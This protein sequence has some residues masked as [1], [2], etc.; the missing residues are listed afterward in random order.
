MKEEPTRLLDLVK[1]SSDRARAVLLFT[2]VACI[3]IFMAAWHELNSSWTFSR[4]RVVQAAAWYVDC[5]EAQHPDVPGAAPTAAFTHDH[6]HILGETQ[7]F[8]DVE[9]GH[10]QRFIQSWHMTPVEIRRRLDLLEDALVNHTMNVTAPLLGFTFD[11]N[12]LGLIGGLSLLF[13]LVWLY[14][15]LRREDSNLGL[16][17]AEQETVNKA[18][19][20]KLASMTQVFTIPPDDVSSSGRSLSAALHKMSRM[21][22]NWTLRLLFLTPVAVQSFVLWLD[23]DTWSKGSIINPIFVRNEF[24]C[25]CLLLALLVLLTALCWRRGVI[26]DRRW[27]RANPRRAAT[28]Q[29]A[30]R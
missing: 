9:L 18:E 17:F 11:V 13:L 22:L 20:Y 12:D 26:M 5:V 29:L 14:F 4:L 16:L 30:G 3:V 1:E 10:A 23:R 7:P 2:Q 27:E 21:A 8:T 24:I 19:I 28:Q 15:S 6:C 25:G